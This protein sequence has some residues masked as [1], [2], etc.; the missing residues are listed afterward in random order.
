MSGRPSI[1]VAGAEPQT[2]VLPHTTGQTANAGAKDDDPLVGQLLGGRYRVLERLAVGGMG[3]VYRA[4]HLGLRKEV[5]IKLVNE[6]GESDHALR[7]LRE[8]MLTSRIDHP[9]VVS[10]L[11][12]GT[13][14][15]GTAYLAMSLA[16]GPTLTN[17]MSEDKPMAWTRAAEIGAQIA[18]AVAAAGA[19]GIVHRDL[20][21]ENIV[22]QPSPDGSQCVKVLD[23]G[24]AKYARDSLAP[25]SAQKAQQVTRVGMMVGTPGYM[26]P[27]QVVGMRADYRAD[28][29]AIGVILWE[30]VAGRKLWDFDDMRELFAKQ[31]G[32]PAPSLRRTCENVSIPAEFDVLVASLLAIKPEGRPQSAAETRD[33]LRAL[34]AVQRTGQ[35][36]AATPSPVTLRHQKPPA[37]PTALLGP[38]QRSGATLKLEEMRILLG[39]DATQRVQADSVDADVLSIPPFAVQF[40]TD[41]QLANTLLEKRVAITLLT[42]RSA[43]TL[44]AKRS[45]ARYDAPQEDAAASSDGALA[46]DASAPIADALDALGAAEKHAQGQPDPSTS[47]AP[48]SQY[49]KGGAARPVVKRLARAGILVVLLISGSAL[50]VH[51]RSSPA[52]A[53]SGAHSARVPR[54]AAPQVGTSDAAPLGAQSVQSVQ[55]APSPIPAELATIAPAELANPQVDRTAPRP[56]RG[57]SLH[58]A[59][60]ER[61]ES[62]GTTQRAH[63][64][65]SMQPSKQVIAS[66]EQL[67]TTARA[68]FVRNE[69]RDAVRLYRLAVKRDPSNPGGHGGLGASLLA[70]GDARAAIAS[71]ERAVALLPGSSGLH[72]ALGR[73]YL[74]AGNRTRAI[75]A[76]RRAVALDPNN[77]TA[78][79]ALAQLAS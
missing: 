17:V 29:Y 12:Y 4:E 7:F 74:V 46:D 43:P 1:R 37:F 15:D 34:I 70:L 32:Q 48:D 19:Q 28:L 27:E 56:A 8:A 45:P 6:S 21:P 2:P 77:R 30:C 54:T 18:D 22:L 42:K 47:V 26:A 40:D 66:A 51:L 44:L 79:A 64:T 31:L 13:F 53:A 60:V 14:D 33:R 35:A 76:Y 55:S 10:A 59:E 65:V 11:D 75:A 71:Y 9:N 49:E 72:A 67:R 25:P 41:A 63:A 52:P 62:F 39:S 3:T 16:S 36:S 50:V 5:A 78:F 23:F 24:I 73:S 61:R 57:A 38:P 58:K 68:H 20:K 69:F